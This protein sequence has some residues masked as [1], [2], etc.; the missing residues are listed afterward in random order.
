MAKMQFYSALKLDGYYWFY[1]V[2]VLECLVCGK[3]HNMET[4]ATSLAQQLSR[5]T[6]LPELFAPLN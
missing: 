3:G 2:M 5:A 4:I 1:T 6:I